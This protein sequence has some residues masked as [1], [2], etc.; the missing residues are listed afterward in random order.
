MV[1][2]VALLLCL[3][4]AACGQDGGSAPFTD[5]R[6]PPSLAPRFFPP[7]GWAWGLVQAGDHPPQRY[8]VASPA[9]D[10]R[11]HVLIL[12]GYGESA[13]AW[14]ETVSDLN[15]R[16]FTVW[17]LDGAGQA[18]SGRFGPVRDL[19]HL[20]AVDPD[21]LGVRAMI[22]MVIP[23]DGKPVILLGSQDGALMA[24]LAADREPRLAGVVASAPWLQ[25]PL[26]PIEQALARV[27]LGGLRGPG[28]AGWS[29][30]HP[31]RTGPAGDDPFRAGVQQAWAVANP[32]LRMGSP[33]AGRRQ[34]MLK[35]RDTIIAGLGDRTPPILMLDA[36]ESLKA[37]CSKV[38][39]C[40]TGAA[41]PGARGPYFQ[42]EADGPREAWLTTVE[43]FMRRQLQRPVKGGSALPIT[44][45]N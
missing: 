18:G 41:P 39:S 10:V 5:S 6:L 37:A 15:R 4:L 24:L 28:G 11:A 32:D 35:A 40:E 31:H 45:S 38:R 21:L 33:S 17:V 42:L 29:R 20:P 30:E 36:P 19:G 22:R 7:E 43:A 23:D 27:G 3:F 44:A 13:E 16:G 12:P 34:A 8:G 14:F 2:R 26:T 1:R 9:T 25:P